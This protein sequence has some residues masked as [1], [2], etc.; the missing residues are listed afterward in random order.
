MDALYNAVV[1]CNF[2]KRDLNDNGNSLTPYGDICMVTKYGKKLD[3]DIKKCIEAEKNMCFKKQN[4]KCISKKHVHCTTT[5]Y[6]VLTSLKCP[7]QSKL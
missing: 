4:K 6:Y 2:V 5:T 3:Q 7:V 1:M